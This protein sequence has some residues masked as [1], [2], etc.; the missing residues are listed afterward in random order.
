MGKITTQQVVL[1]LGITAIL[2]TGAVTLVVLDKDVTI[3][4][5]I[6]GLVVSPILI[7]AGASVASGVSV[8]LENLKDASN[9]NMGAILAM[10]REERD[11]RNAIAAMAVQKIEPVK[12][13]NGHTS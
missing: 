4:L 9:G 1:F 2:M 7:A 5:A 10:L 8:K 13:G 12:E 6:V 11:A 3:I